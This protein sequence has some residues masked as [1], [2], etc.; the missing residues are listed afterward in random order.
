MWFDFFSALW[1]VFDFV[2]ILV[3]QCCDIPCYAK[4][5]IQIEGFRI[6]GD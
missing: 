1:Y 4:Y 2:F 3:F 6:K 5:C